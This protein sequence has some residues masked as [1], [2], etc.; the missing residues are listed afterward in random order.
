MATVDV[1]QGHAAL[2]DHVMLIRSNPHSIYAPQFSWSRS[3][4]L[5]VTRRLIVATRAHAYAW[6]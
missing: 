4:L 2:G 3:G 5:I 6:R 1:A